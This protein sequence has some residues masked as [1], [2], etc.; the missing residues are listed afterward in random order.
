MYPL[1]AQHRKRLVY[2]R[3]HLDNHRAT[4]WVALHYCI[5]QV[6][7]SEDVDSKGILVSVLRMYRGR[8]DENL[9]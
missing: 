6:G 3:F 2:A 5:L 4:F 7:P 8:L 9:G 1:L